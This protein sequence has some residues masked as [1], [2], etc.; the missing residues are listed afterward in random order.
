MFKEKFLKVDG[1]RICYVEEGLPAGRQGKGENII[2]IHGWQGSL[3]YWQYNLLYFA[4][5][6]YQTLALDLPGFGKSSKPKINYSMKYLSGVVKKIIEKKKLDKVS[7]VCHSMGSFIGIDLV[8]RCP[9]KI[10]SLV[11][12]G[13][14]GN[15]GTLSKRKTLARFLFSF[16]FSK[17][18]IRFISAFEFLTLKLYLGVKLLASGSENE[19]RK[20]RELIRLRLSFLGQEFS[21]IYALHSSAMDI[22]R[23][24]WKKEREKLTRINLPALIV[25]GEKEFLDLFASP[26]NSW[27]LF[28]NIKNSQ[29][30]TLKNCGHYSMAEEPDIFNKT[31]DK[32]FRFGIM[33]GLKIEG[34]KGVNKE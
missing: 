11:L 22:I 23:K 18:L 25:R 17:F 13:A 1:L 4:K 12:V 9:Q 28:S 30:V 16:L 5:R 8:L 15:F 24:D 2:F 10:K 14:P 34:E 19:S 27:Y 31:L 26:R 20:I 29:L 3:R 32:F 33:R 21:Y 7:L 6:G